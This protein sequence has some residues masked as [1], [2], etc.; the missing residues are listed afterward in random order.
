MHEK[1]LSLGEAV[2][3]MFTAGYVTVIPVIVLLTLLE[4]KVM[5]GFTLGV[6][7]GI[8]LLIRSDSPWRNLLIASATWLGVCASMLVINLATH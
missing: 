5:F 8:L 1:R 2:Q 7:V 4:N 6:M 3:V